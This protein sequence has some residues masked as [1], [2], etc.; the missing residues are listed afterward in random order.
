[1][2]DI[3]PVPRYDVIL[4][5]LDGTLIDS[6]RETAEAMARVRPMTGERLAI[7]V[8]ISELD[9]FVDQALQRLAL[10]FEQDL[11]VFGRLLEAEQQPAHAVA[12]V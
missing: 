11:L 5:D 2:C 6:E 12:H 9:A 3:H 7:V 8:H 4:F 10:E 1:M